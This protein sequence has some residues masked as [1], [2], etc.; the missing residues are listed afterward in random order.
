M[1]KNNVFHQLKTNIREKTMFRTLLSTNDSG[2]SASGVEHIAANAKEIFLII[3]TFSFRLYSPF[4]VVNTPPH[5]HHSLK[6]N[7]K[8]QCVSST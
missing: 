3:Q 7:N 2:S 8:E 1:I 6:H 4:L 5:R